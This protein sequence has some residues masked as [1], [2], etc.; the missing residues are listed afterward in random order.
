[1]DALD[2]IDEYIWYIAFVLIVC[3]G[4]YATV[5]LKLIQVSGFKEM[6]KVTFLNKSE[7]LLPGLLH[8]H[9]VPYRRG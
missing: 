6:V 8:E 3:A 2:F 7:L 4:I 9:G 1:M 5:R